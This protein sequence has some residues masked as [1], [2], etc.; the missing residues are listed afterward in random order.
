MSAANTG[1]FALCIAKPI[2]TITLGVNALYHEKDFVN[3]FPS[4]PVVQDGACLVWLYTAGA[5]TAASS[6]F[7]GH[8]E[9]VWG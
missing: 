5:A 6:T 7:F 1:T 3:Q 2:A 8:A 4:M 9:K